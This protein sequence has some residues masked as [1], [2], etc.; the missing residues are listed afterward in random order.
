MFKAV[1]N[2]VGNAYKV[3]HKVR[4]GQQRNQE[5]ILLH[6]QSAFKAGLACRSPHRLQNVSCIWLFV[7]SVLNK[8][9][10]VVG[11]CV[12]HFVDSGHDASGWF[13]IEELVIRGELGRQFLWLSAFYRCCSLPEPRE[14]RC[15]PRMLSTNVIC[16]LVFA[17][18]W[19][20]GDSQ[21]GATLAIPG[22]GF[23]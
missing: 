4:Q 11:N 14:L 21:C 17:V 1:A 18:G 9:D 3:G 8:R 19:F 6:N 16:M 12:F 5:A 10:V 15:C 20:N 7:H 2:E 23:A 22:L 13:G